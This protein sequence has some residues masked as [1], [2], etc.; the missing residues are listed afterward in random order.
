MGKP[1]Q[2]RFEGGRELQAALGEIESMATRRGVARRALAKAA[3]PIRDEWASGVDVDSGDLKSSIKIG[4][5]NRKDNRRGN[6]GDVVSTY[7]GLD[8][9]VNKRLSIYGHIEEFGGHSEPANPAGRNAFETKKQ[10]AVD[11]LA[12]D[13]RAELKATADRAARKAAR[14]AAKSAKTA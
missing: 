8:L 11:R 3:I 1:V 7:V 9:S 5:A 4:K 6:R 13:L 12:D 10:T 14:Q 2:F